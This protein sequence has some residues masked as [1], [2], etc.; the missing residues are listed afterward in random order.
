MR[1]RDG[2]GVRVEVIV[3]CVLLCDDVLWMWCGV[4]DVC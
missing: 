1:G 3:V 2:L 4:A